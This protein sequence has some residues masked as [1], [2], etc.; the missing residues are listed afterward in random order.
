MGDQN[1]AT[2]QM[3]IKSIN[4]LNS[5]MVTQIIK[6]YSSWQCRRLYNFLNYDISIEYTNFNTFK[7]K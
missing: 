6:I 3:M 1:G 5:T 7:N 2:V 4:I